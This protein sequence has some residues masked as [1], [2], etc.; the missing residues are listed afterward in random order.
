M[1]SF[2]RGI[3]HDDL[4]CLNKTTK[5]GGREASRHGDESCI[6]ALRAANKER[7]RWRK[8]KRKR[9]IMREAARVSERI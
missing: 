6:S 2:R 5:R 3:R 9:E 4:I 1:S 7:K 8:E